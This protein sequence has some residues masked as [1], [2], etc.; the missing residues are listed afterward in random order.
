MAKTCIG[1]FKKEID[2]IRKFLN[3]RFS[4]MVSENSENKVEVD[5]FIAEFALDC[6]YR[7]HGSLFGLT[8]IE[9]FYGGVYGVTYRRKQEIRLP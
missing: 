8:P 2:D 9:A 7:P 1:N 6:N 4:L 5:E 3:Y